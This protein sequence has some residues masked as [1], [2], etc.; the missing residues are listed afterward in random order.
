MKISISN[1]FLEQT[2]DVL[3]EQA[4][5]QTNLVV[6]NKVE[7]DQLRSILMGQ[8]IERK[9]IAQDLHDAFGQELNAIRLFICAIEKMDSEKEKTK[10]LI[11][12]IKSL[13]DKS[14]TTLKE[15]SIDL[16]PSSLQQL[17]LK[18]T[19]IQ[20]INQQNLLNSN[21]I[22]YELDSLKFSFLKPTENVFVYRIIQEFISNSL[23]HSLAE[24]IYVSISCAPGIFQVNLVDN[25]T[26]FDI[27][28]ETD[29][30]GLNN[31]KS[32]LKALDAQ[33][34]FES[35]P[36]SGTKLNFVINEK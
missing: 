3:Q 31:I 25:G 4:C 27:D 36:T 26:G 12:S 28:R 19:I 30:N 14:I 20:L 9:R 18:K 33:Y 10:E 16:M 8:D 24:N 17:G 6:G 2:N 35:N 29:S 5:H 15:I 34:L 21:L 23:K 22:T 7:N 32:R 13:V 1:D 11:Q